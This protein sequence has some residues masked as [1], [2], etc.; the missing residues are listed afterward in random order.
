MRQL[1]LLFPPLFVHLHSGIQH[2]SGLFAVDVILVGEA[3]GGATTHILM[4]E[5]SFH[6]VQYAFA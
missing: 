5:T 6:F 4:T 3:A 1:R 2:P